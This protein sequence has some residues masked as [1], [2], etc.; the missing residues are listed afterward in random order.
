MSSKIELKALVNGD[1]AILSVGKQVS[2]REYE[3][4]SMAES[5]CGKRTIMDQVSETNAFMDD[6]YKGTGDT[7]DYKINASAGAVQ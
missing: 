5:L 6:F 4:A 1:V 2:R 7:P 3:W